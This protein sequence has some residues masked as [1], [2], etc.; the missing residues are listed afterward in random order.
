MQAFLLSF[1]DLLNFN[2]VGDVALVVNPA[3][4]V[5][6]PCEMSVASGEDHDRKLVAAV[7]EVFLEDVALDDGH[8]PFFALDT[9]VK[10]ANQEVI[11]HRLVI[12]WPERL[13]VVVPAA[14][15]VRLVRDLVRVVRVSAAL[16]STAISCFEARR[17]I[18]GILCVDVLCVDF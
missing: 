3:A 15:R 9:G 8:D 4:Q 1:D 17:R 18:A 5:P 7:D 6:C 14:L 16:T 13:Q 10:I 2:P 11:E 12:P